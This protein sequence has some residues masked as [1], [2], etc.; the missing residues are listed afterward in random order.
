[1]RQVWD[2]SKGS[3][4]VEV[5]VCELESD[6]GPGGD[7]GSVPTAA[8]QLLRVVGAQQVLAVGYASGGVRLWSM[9][10]GSCVGALRAYLGHTGASVRV[11]ALAGAG[12]RLYIAHDDGTL[13]VWDF[14]KSEW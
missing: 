3:V 12:G 5:P 2:V 7:V 6:A 11:A 13:R 8:V 14:A 4:L 9:D 1:M 10:T